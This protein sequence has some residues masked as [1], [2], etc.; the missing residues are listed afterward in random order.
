MAALFV[1]RGDGDGELFQILRRPVERLA[2]SRVGSPVFGARPFAGRRDARGHFLGRN[3][4][5]RAFAASPSP[6]RHWR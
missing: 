6:S 4:Q 1:Y 3:L 2:R 5:R